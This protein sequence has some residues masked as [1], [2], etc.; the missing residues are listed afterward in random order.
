MRFLYFFRLRF[1]TLRENKLRQEQGL[2]TQKLHQ[3]DGNKS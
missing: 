3:Y 1:G 2:Q